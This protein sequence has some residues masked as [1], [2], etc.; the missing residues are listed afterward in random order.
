ML[1]GT[2]LH[3]APVVWRGLNVRRVTQI[4]DAVPRNVVEPLEVHEFFIHAAVE[5]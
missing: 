4:L 5:A 2:E 3:V 1:D